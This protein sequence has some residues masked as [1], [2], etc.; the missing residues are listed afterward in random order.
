MFSSYKMR[1]D[2][3]SLGLQATLRCLLKVTSWI[4]NL[5]CTFL[6]F[7]R[8]TLRSKSS[9]WTKKSRWEQ[10]LVKQQNFTETSWSVM[11]FKSLWVHCHTNIRWY[12]CDHLG[13]GCTV[14]EKGKKRA[15]TP[16]QK[17]I[18]ERSGRLGRRKGQRYPFPCLDYRSPR[19]ARRCFFP[20]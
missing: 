7:F 20:F 13:P 2:T 8:L 11:H 1:L 10:K 19:F 3:C 17:N 5:V 6:M 4:T 14:G 9:K 16:K 15:E 12:T 18:G